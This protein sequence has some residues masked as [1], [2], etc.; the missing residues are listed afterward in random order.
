M[1]LGFM[2]RRVARP[3]TGVLCLRLYWSRASRQVCQIVDS[4]HGWS[5]P[6]HEFCALAN[7]QGLVG[8]RPSPAPSVAIGEVAFGL[9]PRSAYGVVYRDTVG[10]VGS[11]LKEM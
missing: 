3:Q 10:G 6:W 11:Y 7:G 2:T 1:V 4:F 8:R 5:G 9:L